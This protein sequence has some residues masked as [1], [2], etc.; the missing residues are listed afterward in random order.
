[1]MFKNSTMS[2][3]SGKQTVEAHQFNIF[4]NQMSLLQAT[5]STLTPSCRNNAAIN[6]PASPEFANNRVN[7]MNLFI[8]SIR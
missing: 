3:N 8:A 5:P 2:H 7:F 6:L 1:M 4:S